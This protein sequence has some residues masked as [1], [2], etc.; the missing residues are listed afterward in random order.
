MEMAHL[1]VNAKDGDDEGPSLTPLRGDEAV[2]VRFRGQKVAEAPGE[3]VGEGAS[4]VGW[5]CKG[6]GRI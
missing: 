1:V 2:R 5:G 6:G 3:R 4:P